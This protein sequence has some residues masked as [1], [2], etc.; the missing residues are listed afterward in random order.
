V[1]FFESSGFVLAFVRDAASRN[2]QPDLWRSA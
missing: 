1:V 2:D